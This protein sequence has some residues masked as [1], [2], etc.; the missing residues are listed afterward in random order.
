M[1]MKKSLLI[2]LCLFI[3]KASVEQVI[4]DLSKKVIENDSINFFIEDVIVAQDNKNCIGFVEKGIENTRV[5]A[6]FETDIRSEIK[7]LFDN[8]FPK[9]VSKRPLILRINNFMIYEASYE[10][11][12]L[13][14]A[15]LNLSF[16]E[17]KDST[18]LEK[19]R[20]VLSYKNA[21]TD[22]TALH[23]KNIIA[24][25]ETCLNN[26][27]RREKAGSL[28]NNRIH[29]DS[30]NYFTS[31]IK[32]TKVFQEKTT[33]KGIYWCFSDF[34]DQTPDTISKFTVEYLKNTDNLKQ[35]NLFLKNRKQKKEIWGFCDGKDFFVKTLNTFTQI[36]I[37]DNEF[38]TYLKMS[39]LG[40]PGVAFSYAMFGL[41]GGAI[42]ASI[43]EENSGLHAA[44]IRLTNGT[45]A[46]KEN[47]YQP[48][49]N[50]NYVFYYSKYSKKDVPVQLYVNDNLVA[51][52]HKNSYYTL[53]I[54]ASK[55]KV[56]VKLKY[57]NGI[58][59]I[60]NLDLN[61][62]SREIFLFKIKKNGDIFLDKLN[63]KM[64]KDIW[65]NIQDLEEV[66]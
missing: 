20:G 56:D 39:T 66:Y 34:C 31:T 3:A 1:T 33:Q 55:K 4:L 27:K 60:E 10:A 21:R 46:L 41:V 30:L 47:N 17:K 63:E 43:A 11:L 9:E 48:H 64:E 58:N 2:L 16:I 57:E 13:S 7:Q 35:A 52:I 32:E 14:S 51:T 23:K 65:N 29:P 62:L 5:A 53:K 24:A 26:F 12:Y 42:A 19:Y 25:F 40:S 15:D 22:N 18:Y 8:S 45:L 37:G 6:Y 49:T 61:I 28:L 50:T 59:T 44:K 36:K 38:Q 54:P